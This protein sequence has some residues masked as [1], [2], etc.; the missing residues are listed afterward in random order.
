VTLLGLWLRLCA[1]TVVAVGSFVL[2]PVRTPSTNVS[3]GTA[4]VLGCIAGT[5]LFV[6]L[7]RS[8]PRTRLE[9]WSR[10]DWTRS[11]FLVLWASVEEAIWRR[12]ALGAIALHTGWGTALAAS[13]V[14]F[15]LTHRLGKPTQ[16]V[17]GLAFGSIYLLTGQLVAAIAMH[18]VYNLLL[19]R[20]L[21]PQ[22]STRPA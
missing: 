9:R 14:A 11:S 2:L 12:L 3:I 17:T 16:L 8:R 20:A 22:P 21:G 15:A 13:T 4:G 18:A 6:G 5:C 7:A 19:D 10:R 1:G